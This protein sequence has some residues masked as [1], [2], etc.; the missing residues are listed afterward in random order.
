MTGPQRCGTGEVCAVSREHETEYSYGVE[1]QLLT[2]QQFMTFTSGK[3]LEEATQV[4]TYL[5]SL[6]GGR[7]LTLQLVEYTRTVIGTYGPELQS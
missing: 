4:M 1:V 2:L 3:T 7:E 5:R 6:Q